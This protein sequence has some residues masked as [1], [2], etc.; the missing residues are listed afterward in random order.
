MTKPHLSAS[1]LR[2]LCECGE[3]YRRRYIDGDVI[4]PG[5]SMVGGIA[6]HRA[7][8]RNLRHKLEH[9]ALLEVDA[10]CQVARDTAGELW[11]AG[12]HF[13]PDEM[14]EPPGVLFGQIVD[15]STAATEKH[16]T[17]LHPC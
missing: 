16:A 9:G 15:F 3:R 4:P 5:V 12:V 1:S 10:A 2:M 17:D 7:A 14:K 8:E 6:V 11:N 13:S